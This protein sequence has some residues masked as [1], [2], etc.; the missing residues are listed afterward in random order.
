MGNYITFP[1]LLIWLPLLAATFSFI[2]KDEKGSKNSAI[3]F[4]LLILGVSVA[5]LFF[6]NDTQYLSYNY[7][8][9]IW[10]KYMGANYFIGLDGTGRLLTLLT[11][12]GFPLI[13]ISTSNSKFENPSSIVRYLSDAK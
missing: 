4:S 9:Y 3:I 11:A 13:L 5:T 8:N 6:T 2:S 10:L 1:D 12:I 7:V